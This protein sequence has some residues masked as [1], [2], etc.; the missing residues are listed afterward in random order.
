MDIL[1]SDAF[2]SH[3]SRPDLILLNEVSHVQSEEFA[4]TVL[5]NFSKMPDAFACSV[6]MPARW[7]VGLG[8]GVSCIAAIHAGT[9]SR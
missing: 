9:S 3:G 4:L 6:R 5:D 2:S 1:T 7:A 8:V